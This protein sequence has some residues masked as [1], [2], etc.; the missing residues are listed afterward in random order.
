MNTSSVD[1]MMGKR[2]LEEN[3][4]KML[5]HYVEDS[6]RMQIAA[7]SEISIPQRRR[8]AQ[9]LRVRTEAQIKAIQDERDLARRRHD[10]EVH[11][12]QALAG[13]LER[14]QA[15][16][17][18]KEREVQRI[19]GESEELKE[20]ELKLKVAYMNKERAAQ[21]E[22]RILQQRRHQLREHAIDDQMEC[23]RR[24]AMRT[25]SE[26]SSS[27]KVV[28]LRQ[29]AALQE[30]MA[31]RLKLAEEARLEADRD[32]E[33]VEEVV[34]KIVDED[35]GEAV[36]R[37]KRKNE[38]RALIKQ[39]E[40][41]RRA[42]LVEAKE[43]AA[44][45][46]AQI[47]QHADALAARES[48][49][50]RLKAEKKARDKAAFERIVAET[51][52]HRAEEEE[53]D[54]LRDLLWEEEME[55]QRRKEE[56]DREEKRQQSKR[57]MARANEEMLAAKQ[58]QRES[59]RKEEQRLVETMQRKFA[60]DER[61]ER[62]MGERRADN[63]IKYIEAV[64]IQKL[65]R[66]AVYEQAK[67]TEINENANALRAEEYRLKVVQEARRRLLEEHAEDLQGFLPKGTIQPDDDIFLQS[68]FQSGR[69]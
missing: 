33:L 3:N 35:Y 15:E 54:Q 1:T 6:S 60:D 46:D 34:K 9:A 49:L 32:R 61:N 28:L 8:A 62:L 40:A 55:A 42:E 7:Q 22:E 26:K 68:G 64:K 2:R 44:F 47:R 11:Q 30:Q 59:E 41:Q 37:A 48:E 45:E 36:E 52:K 66:A 53:L 51:E 67:Q 43:Q 38:C 27:K 31:D 18:R 24:A 17:E 4:L 16:R 23:D 12:S 14:R 57:D 69:V 29:K 19:C 10:L 25:E 65:E 13:E 5:H 21:H 58:V 63:K 50:Y 39:Y 56:R 20:L